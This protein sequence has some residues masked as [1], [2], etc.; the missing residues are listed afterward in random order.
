MQIERLPSIV[1]D[2]ETTKRSRIAKPSN[3]RVSL[4]G[5]VADDTFLVFQNFLSPQFFFAHT[6]FSLR[7]RDLGVCGKQRINC[8]FSNM[9]RNSSAAGAMQN[10]MIMRLQE[11]FF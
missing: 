10:E 1:F 3:R 11:K 6:F 4:E 2:K 8:I 7:L 5:D 9:T